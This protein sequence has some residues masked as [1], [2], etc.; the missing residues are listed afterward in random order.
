MG[1]FHKSLVWTC[2]NGRCKTSISRNGRSS[3]NIRCFTQRR[4]MQAVRQ[5]RSNDSWKCKSNFGFIQK[6]TLFSFSHLNFPRRMRSWLPKIW[7]L[8]EP[9]HH[10]WLRTVKTHQHHN[11]PIFYF[12]TIKSIV[13]KMYIDCWRVKPMVKAIRKQLNQ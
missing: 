10:H 8:P 7:F 11:H 5:R 12:P 6:L 13:W 2:W 4:T 1:I 9:F 3:V